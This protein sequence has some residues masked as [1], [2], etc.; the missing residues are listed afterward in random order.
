MK[1]AFFHLLDDLLDHQSES[2]KSIEFCLITHFYKTDYC[3]LLSNGIVILNYEWIA[4]FM[5]ST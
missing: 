1:V 4:C 2:E 3:T 5:Q